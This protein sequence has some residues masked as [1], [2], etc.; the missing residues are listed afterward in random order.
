MSHDP[1]DSHRTTYRST[2]PQPTG[3]RPRPAVEPVT[4]DV[5]SDVV[6]PWCYVGK[7]RLDKALRMQPD[8]P[9]VVQVA[10]LPARP[11]DSGRRS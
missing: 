1:F 3:R 8:T 4:I 6:C 5:V 7:R 11:D 10:P 2:S 9:V